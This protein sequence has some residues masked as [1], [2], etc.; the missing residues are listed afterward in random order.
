MRRAI[1]VVLVCLLLIAG[2]IGVVFWGM[3]GSWENAP[4]KG[5]GATVAVMIPKGAGPQKVA[6]LLEEHE[7]VG[8][9]GWFYR[10]VRY[11][12]RAA[13]Q[14]K[15]GELAFRDDMS[16]KEVLEVLTHGTPITHKITVPE[17]L[18][19]D[20]IAAL[21]AAQ[22]LADAEEFK[23]LAWDKNFAAEL[24]VPGASLEGFLYPET[25]HF[26]KDTPTKKVLGT[27]VESYRKVYNDEFRKRAKELGLS[28]LEVVTLASIV[29]KETG[30]PQER[31]HI[32]GVF[33]NRLQQNWRMDTDPTVIYAVLLKR[34][35]FDGN[36]T[37]EDLEIESP[38]NTYRNKGLPPG[39]ICSPG[40]AAIEA[41]LWPEKT[42][43]MF[44]VSKN[45]GTHHFCQTLSCHERA[46]QRYQG[47]G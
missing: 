43:H 17:G 44:F 33:H 38:Y 3:I 22:D 1:I 32:A 31:A 24:G 19:I 47:G 13:G 37:R 23:K 34:G 14:L 46:V 12:K 41:A 11:Y 9:A 26:R 20:E 28:E 8:S 42:K 7:V 15:A 30:A 16:P 4:M 39:P 35:S 6:E 36:L 29:E 27:M 25:Y 40:K 18:R 10:Y 5:K 21:F 45:N 2:I